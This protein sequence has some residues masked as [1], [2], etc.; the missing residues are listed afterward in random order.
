VYFLRGGVN[1]WLEDVINPTLRANA[2]AKDSIAFDGVSALSRYFGG[3]PRV[4]EPTG[5]KTRR[6]GC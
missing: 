4:G 6:R 2:L 5:L 1:E 3:T